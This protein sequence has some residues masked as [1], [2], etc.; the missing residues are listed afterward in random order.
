MIKRGFY[1]L[2]VGRRRMWTTS[3]QFL[4]SLVDHVFI[5]PARIQGII[6]TKEI[7]FAIV[8]GSNA[9]DGLVWKTA[10]EMR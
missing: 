4:R 1:T 6:T 5:V 9:L 8:A 7:N 10:T 2:S 3:K